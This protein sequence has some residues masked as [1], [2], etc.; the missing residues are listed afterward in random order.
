MRPAH[1]AQGACK[2]RFMPEMLMVSAGQQRVAGVP[3]PA[4]QAR[5]RVAVTALALPGDGARVV[6]RR[7]AGSP[8]NTRSSATNGRIS[9]GTPRCP[10][11]AMPRD[12]PCPGPGSTACGNAGPSRSAGVP[13]RCTPWA[14]AAVPG[15][16]PTC[17]RRASRAGRG[18]RAGRRRGAR[19]GGKR[20]PLPDDVAPLTWDD[21]RWRVS[22]GS[23]LD[24]RTAAIRGDGGFP[25]TTSSRS[26]SPRALPGTTARRPL[27]PGPGGASRILHRVG[28]PRDA[29]GQPRR[30]DAATFSGSS[31]TRP[32]PAGRRCPVRLGRR[33]A[34]VTCAQACAV[35]CGS[36]GRRCVVP[37]RRRGAEL[38]LSGLW[39]DGTRCAATVNTGRK[40]DPGLPR[41]PGQDPRSD[42]KGAVVSA[43]QMHTQRKHV[44]KMEQAGAYFLFTIGGNQEK[45]STRP[46]RCPGGQSRASP[47]P[48]TGATAG[49]TCAPSRP[50]RPRRRSWRN[51]PKCGR[52]SSSSGTAT[53]R[54][55]N[56]WARSPSSAWPLPAS[57]AGAADLLAYL[58]G[59]WSIEKC[60]HMSVTSRSGRTGTAPPR[61]AAPSPPS[62]TPLPP[63]PSASSAFPASPPAPRQ[64]PRPLPA[65]LPAP[66]PRST[67]AVTCL[68]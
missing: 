60:T 46:T 3:L 32:T 34:P 45:L 30:P 18:G 42:L 68:T 59:H 61:P 12:A 53:A 24:V 55:A 36:T 6:P 19:P 33:C 27:R 41:P 1:A 48:S 22:S 39:D 31:A 21:A 38:L 2:V 57:E 52:C 64:P 51:G 65:T 14:G 56:C 28:A 49:S 8:R 11:S 37:P 5:C 50:S 44:Q 10:Q 17:R 54:T 67:S 16:P 9:E 43:D 23:A 29:A 66:R 15:F 25:W 4:G 40:R 58:R 62:A 35:T 63:A 20:S 7:C 26:R 47:G 13:A